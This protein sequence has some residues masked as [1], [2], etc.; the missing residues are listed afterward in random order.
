M[1]GH[2]IDGEAR[3]RAIDDIIEG[4]WRFKPPGFQLRPMTETSSI[5]PAGSVVGGTER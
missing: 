1:G 5:L 4:A 3:G 2:G